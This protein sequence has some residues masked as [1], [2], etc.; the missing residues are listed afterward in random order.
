MMR[1][2]A[3]TYLS[4]TCLPPG[5]GAGKRDSGDFILILAYSKEAC[6]IFGLKRRRP[7]HTLPV[8]YPVPECT[9]PCMLH[10]GLRKE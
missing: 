8:Q 10:P 3:R 9:Q 1:S 7:I 5:E 4:I 2:Y 6:V